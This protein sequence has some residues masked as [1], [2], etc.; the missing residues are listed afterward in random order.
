MTDLV[1]SGS[2]SALLIQAVAAA[3]ILATRTFVWHCSHD[4]A[5]A[6][7]ETAQRTAAAGA[8]L[9]EVHR[10]AQGDPTESRED[11]D[12]LLNLIDRLDFNSFFNPKPDIRQLFEAAA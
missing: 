6:E 11:L 2:A 8:G 10:K 5:V 7:G 12:S 3:A 9:Q 4:P 1:C